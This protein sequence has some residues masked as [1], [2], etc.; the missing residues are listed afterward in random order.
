MKNQFEII[1]G[2]RENQC[3][4]LSKL[5]E[6][7]HKLESIFT[8]IDQIEKFIEIVQENVS[9]VELKV[10]QAEKELGN[11]M[12]VKALGGNPLN[13]LRSR[14]QRD[15]LED[16]PR[17]DPPRIVHTEQFFDKNIEAINPHVI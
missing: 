11:N 17:W 1:K 5:K 15:E 12:I 3:D 2:I 7:T 13:L 6:N 10:T 16:R 14:K 9:E 8:Q 4:K